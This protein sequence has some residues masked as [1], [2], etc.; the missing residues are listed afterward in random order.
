MFNDIDVMS[1]LSGNSDIN[2]VF[3]YVRLID[4]NGHTELKIEDN[5]IIPTSKLCYCTW[6]EGRPCRNCISHQ[7]YYEEKHMTKLQYVGNRI[8]LIMAIPVHIQDNKYVLEMS[9]DITESLVVND[10]Y[11][12]DN[13][14]I[15]NIIN[16][17]NV[18]AVMDPFTNLY[19]KKYIEKQM[20]ED[21]LEINK[22][23]ENYVIVLFDIDNF[24]WVNDTYGHSNGDI[25]IQDFVRLIHESTVNM[26]YW[27]ARYGG[28]EFLLV[29]SGVNIEDVIECCKNIQNKMSEIIYEVDSNKYSIT[30]SYGVHQFVHGVDTYNTM[31]KLVDEAMYK[32]KKYK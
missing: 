13:T 2:G 6:R 3:D 24:K 16:E 18:V 25:A 5:H 20:R 15:H 17:L 28:D 7:A 1:V 14:D 11:H 29:F 10:K 22:S 32:N 31:I 4:L 30:A 19:N 21:I 27:A 9:K 12:P 26:N 23:K 8:Q